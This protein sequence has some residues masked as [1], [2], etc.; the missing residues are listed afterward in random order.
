M[1]EIKFS[2]YF[3][4]K[5]QSIP[6]IQIIPTDNNINIFSSC[7]C[8]N[9]YQNIDLFIKNNYYKDIIEINKIPKDEYINE[10]NKK[11]DI[12]LIINKYNITKEKIN[13]EAFE[14]KN[15]IIDIY[16]RKI[17]EINEIYD[18]YIINN[19]KIIVILEQMI[20]SYQLIKDNLANIKNI[21][22]NCNFNEQNKSKNLLNRNYCIL[23][24]FHN[25]IKN[26]FQNEYIISKSC[27]KEGFEISSL[28]YSKNSVKN[29]LEMDNNLCASCFNNSPNV[30]L[31]N[32]NNLNE[33]KISFKA[34]S[35]KANWIIKS[36]K[37]NLI[38]C[39]DDGLIKIWPTINESI[40]SEK[41]KTKEN[42]ENPYFR[43]NKIIN[44]NLNTIFEYN[45][46]NNEI[47]KLIKMIHL[48]E[49]Q[50]IGFSEKNIFLFKY[51]I[52]ENVM[53]I[54]S[55]KDIPCKYMIDFYV[56]QKDK[57]EIIA[58]NSINN[59]YFFSIPNFECINKFIVKSMNKNSLVQINE[60]EILIYDENDLKIID[61]NRFQCKLIIKGK[62]NNDF[63]LNINDG[64]I[65]QSSYLGIKRFSIK[66][67]NE[68]PNLVLFNSDEDN[69]SYN[70][71]NYVE[72][73]IY[74]FKLKDKR[75]ITCYQNGKIEICKLKHI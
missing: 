39:G 13:K 70:Y 22:N 49:N 1:E 25:D 73:V 67:M 28:F 24:T 71:E 51:I 30:I 62:N 15:K 32:L 36:N 12:N 66:T 50:F 31:F 8:N 52:N 43:A 48:K 19:K 74:I 2:G 21:L 29:F 27:I 7:K 63:L 9:K 61:I 6:L 60:T 64:T 45:L 55:K 38:T 42:K 46:D 69:D 65:I 56:L 11:I 20:K 18:K 16:Q 57:K 41:V 35:Q 4:K 14:L 17:Y 26:Y 23:E 3:C 10:N 47:S 58:M 40:L 54:E 59:L 72:K 33:E 53:N 34:H 44:I 75:I 68:L 5:C 37:N